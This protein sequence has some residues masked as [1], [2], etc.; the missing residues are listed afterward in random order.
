[1]YKEL[2]SH[3]Y[4]K[5]H[6]YL[7]DLTKALEE[8]KDDIEYRIQEYGLLI[9]GYRFETTFTE[10]SEKQEKYLLIVKAFRIENDLKTE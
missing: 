7:F 3:K 6:P 10:P 4:F 5:N 2:F 9:E 1:M 8:L